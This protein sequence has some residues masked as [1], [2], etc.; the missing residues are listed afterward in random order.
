MG[1]VYHISL[2]SRQ[3]KML[4]RQKDSFEREVEMRKC[5]ECD[6]PMPEGARVTAVVCGPV[7][8]KL[9]RTR[10]Q[11]EYY[12]KRKQRENPGGPRITARD[13]SD[14]HADE[15]DVLRFMRVFPE[16]VSRDQ[17]GLIRLMDGGFC[18]VA[19]EWFTELDLDTSLAYCDLRGA[20]WR[21]ADINHMNLTGVNLRGSNLVGAWAYQTNFTSAN[22]TKSNA[23]DAHFGGADFT[24]ADM[25]G[26]VFT[27]S[28]F[29]EAKMNRATLNR[30]WF[31]KCNF[32]SV[33]MKNAEA[34]DGWF[35]SSSF[36]GSDLSGSSFYCARI[37]SAD[38]TEACLKEAQFTGV[39][40]V[41]AVF[42]DA[43]L[44]GAVLSGNFSGAKFEGAKLNGAVMN[45][46]PAE[47]MVLQEKIGERK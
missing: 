30:G 36:Y 24:V 38:F 17:T 22:I 40:A 20:S 27:M 12:H 19:N 6:G 2:G 23:V 13:L 1:V 45:G 7:C 35:N 41:G 25:S 10:K 37:H 42:R 21:R 46:E 29:G 33:E 8:R 14:I 4:T 3:E 16:G 31:E 32:D 15:K 47:K 44:R 34:V 11:C 26:G 18:S 5:Q 43:D 9:R 39:H 28:F